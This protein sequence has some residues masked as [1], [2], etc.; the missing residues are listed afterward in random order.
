[1]T[2]DRRQFMKTG[3]GVVGGLYTGLAQAQVKPC[4]P[5]T[6]TVDQGTPVATACNI[7]A[8]AD[9]QTRISGPGVVWHHNFESAAEVNAFRWSAGYMGGN[10][11]NDVQN[12]GRVRWVANDGFAGGGCLEM[13]RT[14]GTSDGS[15]W[16]RPLSPLSAPGNGKAQ[17]DPAANGT[18]TVRSYNS[19]NGGSQI[20]SHQFGR[21]GNPAYASDGNFDGNEYWLQVR[22]KYD[23][24]RL[25]A[26]NP[27]G[28]KMFYFTLCEISAP[29]QEIITE[30]RDQSHNF[31]LLS[32]YRSVGPP[33]EDDTS[34]GGNQPGTTIGTVG[35]GVCYFDNSNGRRAN[36]WQFPTDQWVT[37]LYHVVLGTDEG[38]NTT[39]EVSACEPGQSVYRQIWRQTTVNLPYSG[40]RPRCHSALI[41]SQYMNGQNFGTA[42]A[43]RFTQMIF[44]KQFIPPPSV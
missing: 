13:N 30:S 4:P 11:P 5:P 39:V 17:N 34:N 6:I 43:H 22:V 42:F 12:P 40:G 14:T 9:W 23:S 44:S 31:P 20:N 37:L 18:L 24:R 7:G 16:W 8:A 15:E 29:L 38:S 26:N 21:Y 33:L 19:T 1:M 3:A 35:N 32:M 41:V 10:D 36:C 27:G 28:G 25:A 2:M